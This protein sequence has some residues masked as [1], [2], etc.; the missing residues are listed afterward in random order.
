MNQQLATDLTHQTTILEH[1][2]NEAT[3]FLNTLAERSVGA[4]GT[5]EQPLTLL[6]AL[7]EHGIGG[8]AALEHFKE[9]YLPGMS[10]SPGPRYWGFVT[11][12]STPAALAGDWLTSTLDQNA[13]GSK[14]SIAPWLEAE[15]MGFLRSLFGLSNNHMGSFVTGA[16]MANVVGL[17][18]ARQWVGHELGIN[19]A[20]EGVAAVGAIPI[21]SATPHSSTYKAL[22]MVGMGRNTLQLIQCLPNRESMDIADL[23]RNLVQLDGRPGIV[24]ASAG[25]VNTVDFDDLDA[26]TLLKERY[27]FWLHVDAAFGGFAACSPKYDHLISGLDEADSITIDAHKW[28]NVPYD[29]AM[30]FTQ[31]PDLQAQVFQNAAAYITELTDPTDY[32]HRTPE[33][34]RRL[35]ALPA[36]FTL[37]AYGRSGYQEIVERNCRLVQELAGRIEQS[38]RFCLLAPVRLNGICFTLKNGRS[39]ASEVSPTM[40]QIQDFLNRLTAG[41]KLF[42]TPTVLWNRP[43]IR[44]SIVNWQTVEE[45]IEIGW[46][47]LLRAAEATS[48]SG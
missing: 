28:L 23:E 26:I 39:G 40:E 10:A 11:G 38:D 32:V 41:G 47:A 35:R 19:I 4:M 30:Q 27:P 15:T 8:V 34:S 18:T 16:T 29:G 46:N 9:R 7:P 1:T 2:L 42:L 5:P 44:V 3:D 22:S 31:R 33:S 37:I 24:V 17:A 12:G 6:T 43:A 45:D 13:L 36:W 20:E 21:L 48:S 25:T 14:E